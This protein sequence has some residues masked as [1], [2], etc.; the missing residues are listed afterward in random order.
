MTALRECPFCGKKEGMEVESY[1]GGESYFV[2]CG[3]PCFAWLSGGTSKEDAI[4]YWNTRPLEDSLRADLAR[5]REL[6]GEAWK[7]DTELHEVVYHDYFHSATHGDLTVKYDE[8][9]TRIQ[10]E[11]KE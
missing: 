1:D 9:R 8:L 3:D 6:L 11:L 4:K 7:H 5:L 10:S 2:D